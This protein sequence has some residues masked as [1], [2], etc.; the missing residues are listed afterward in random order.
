MSRRVLVAR[1]YVNQGVR[2]AAERGRLMEESVSFDAACAD[3]DGPECMAAVRSPEVSS[4]RSGCRSKGNLNPF[5]FGREF[6]GPST[7]IGSNRRYLLYQRRRTLKALPSVNIMILPRDTF[8]EG[9][10][11][12]VQGP[13]SARCPTTSLTFPPSFPRLSPG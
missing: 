12:R 3:A 4:E 11:A 13:L 2:F 8:D 7:I 10:G 5:C 6:K 1:M 9:N